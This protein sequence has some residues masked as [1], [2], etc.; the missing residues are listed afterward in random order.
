MLLASLRFLIYILVLLSFQYFVY[1]FYLFLHIWKDNKI[2]FF[3]VSC[4]LSIY[5]SDSVYEYYSIT[6]QAF[7]AEEM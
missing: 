3:L 4:T 5:V 6:P 2:I 1:N 7:H